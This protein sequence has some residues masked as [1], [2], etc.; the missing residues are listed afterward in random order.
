MK[1]N[2][3]YLILA[4]ILLFSCEEEI[5]LELPETT[6]KVVVEGYIQPSYPIFL[7]L[8]KSSGYF[9]EISE[10]ELANVFINNAN[11]IVTRMSDNTSLQLYFNAIDSLGD[12]GIYSDMS[13]DN[14]IGFNP[15][16][17]RIDERYKL[18]VIYNDDTIT[19]ITGIPNIESETEKMIDSVWFIEDPLFPNYGDFYMSYNDADT[20]GNNIMLESKRISHHIGD[21][22]YESD[23]LFVKALWGKVRND[24]EGLNGIKN[25]ETYFDR[26]EN[27][28]FGGMEHGGKRDPL[29]GNFQT[30]HLDDSLGYLQADIALI[31]ISQIERAPFEFWRSTEFQ[32]QMNG[33]PFA[34]PMNLQH[35]IVNG[36]GVWE[37][38]GAIYYK[39]IAKK[40]TT[41]TE[42]YT[43]ELFEAF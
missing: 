18:E 16:F 19:S 10:N 2:L 26:G 15:E 4:T 30:E 27:E 29:I 14:P 31:R 39:V 40:D 5:T 8:T 11:V 21:N 7:Q 34:E 43:P 36:L 22:I 6:D 25:F 38:K 35:N 33:N 24:F 12:I 13:I 23:P 32:E 28:M 37:G 9:D 17:A 20:L 42:R 3:L 41:F 1:R